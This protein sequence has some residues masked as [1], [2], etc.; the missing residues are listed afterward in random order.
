MHGAIYGLD[1]FKILLEHILKICGNTSYESKHIT[2]S[3]KIQNECPLILR[4]HDEID[5]TDLRM[6]IGILQPEFLPWI[7]IKYVEKVKSILPNDN[8]TD[9]LMVMN[10]M[11]QSVKNHLKQ[12]QATY[13]CPPEIRFRRP[14]DKKTM[15]IPWILKNIAWCKVKRTTPP[16]DKIQV[17]RVH[18]LNIYKSSTVVTWTAFISV[19]RVICLE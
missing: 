8:L 6:E 12:I 5:I 3:N 7:C 13:K 15:S 19:K 11:V 2:S 10:P 9:N 17:W 1:V 4:N 14:F 16:N 18:S